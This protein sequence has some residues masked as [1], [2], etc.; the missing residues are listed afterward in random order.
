MRRS[1]RRE[2]LVGVARVRAEVDAAERVVRDV[3][4]DVRALDDRLHH[5]ADLRLGRRVRAGAALL[6]LGRPLHREVA[7]QVEA[8][9]RRRDLDRDAV[10]VPDPPLP[11]QPVELAVLVLVGVAPDHQP[12]LVRMRLPGAVRVARPASSGSGRRRRC[13]PR[14]ARRAPR[15]SGHGRMLE[16]TKRGRSASASSAP[17]GIQ[18]RDDV[19]ARVSSAPSHLLVAAVARE[20]PV[21]QMERRR[22]AGHLDRVDVRLDRSAGFSRSARSRCS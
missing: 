21:D 4:G 17:S 11:E 2:V 3:A 14:R 10:V 9:E 7:V 13:P 19:E 5:R 18:P 16:R 20:Q 6:G 8:L 15:R 1:L 12:R 22:A